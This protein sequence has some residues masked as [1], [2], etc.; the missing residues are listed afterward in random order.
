MP[1]APPTPLP[2]ELVS[3]KLVVST[4]VMTQVPLAFVLTVWLAMVTVSPVLKPCAVDV[5]ILMGLALVDA[6][7]LSWS[8]RDR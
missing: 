7:M 5:V 4:T 6:E 1:V 2:V 3:V 8:R